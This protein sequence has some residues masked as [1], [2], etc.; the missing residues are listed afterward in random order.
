MPK[1]EPLENKPN[2]YRYKNKNDK[3]YKYGVRRTYQ[4]VGQKRAEFT[5]SGLKSPSDAKAVLDK[6]NA[7]LYADKIKPRDKAKMTVN[8]CFEELSTLKYESGKWRKTS[9][10]T[11]RN[12]YKNHLANRFGDVSISSVT[13]SNYQKFIN[14]LPQSN[15]ATRTI[16]LINNC[17]QM[18]FNYAEYNDY[19]VKS[20]I[21]YIDIPEGKKARN[22]TIERE[23]YLRW[24]KTAEEILPSYYYSIVRLTSLGERRGEL[25]GLRYESFELL[26]LTNGEKRYKITFDVA[27]NPVQEGP[28]KLKTTASYRSI[29]AG[30]DMTEHIENILNESKKIRLKKNQTI[31]P[32][33]F[34]FVSIRKGLPVVPSYLDN[35]FSKV[36]KKCGIHIHPHKLRHYFA[37]IAS[38]EE[39]SST[40]VMRWLGYSKFDMTES[41]VRSNTASMLNVSNELSGKI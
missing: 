12:V 16:K 27:R 3:K 31:K 17:M 34:V 23:D 6:F 40:S 5:K 9:L 28:S 41:Y 25:V 8:E 30:K 1:W 33:D 37:T 36:S 7:D 14:D 29:V 13:R 10:V 26:T 20:K 39:I 19:I 15:Y 4:L 21:K 24:M 35:I 32:N 18:I 2:I 11:T 22:M 38:E